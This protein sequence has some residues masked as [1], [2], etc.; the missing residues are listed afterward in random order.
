MSAKQEEAWIEKWNELYEKVEQKPSLLFLTCDWYE[1][2]LDKALGFIQEEA[3]QD[4]QVEYEETW[5]KGKKALRFFR[6][7]MID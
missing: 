1:I 3:Y 4:Y 6:G 5:Y 7:T 2:S